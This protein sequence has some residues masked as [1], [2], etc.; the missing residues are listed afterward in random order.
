MRGADILL[1]FHV[2]SSF[3]RV[4]HG[5]THHCTRLPDVRWD[6]PRPPSHPSLLGNISHI[7]PFQTFRSSPKWSMSRSKVN[8]Y[9]RA[10]RMKGAQQQEAGL[11]ICWRPQLAWWGTYADCALTLGKVCFNIIITCGLFHYSVAIVKP[12]PQESVNEDGDSRI[13]LKTLQFQVWGRHFFYWR[14]HLFLENL[15]WLRVRLTMDVGLV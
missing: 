12:K 14:L 1:L 8:C 2:P 3:M 4:V 6:D 13:T 9:S 5:V 10:G 7:L 15:K 11:S